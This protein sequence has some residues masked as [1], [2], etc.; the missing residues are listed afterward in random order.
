MDSDLPPLRDAPLQDMELAAGP[1]FTRGR[2]RAGTGRLSLQPRTGPRAWR[3][4]ISPTTHQTGTRPHSRGTEL[5]ID[6]CPSENDSPRELGRPV[7][8]CAGGGMPQ[9]PTPLKP[10]PTPPRRIGP[11]RRRMRPAREG[12]TSGNGP[13]TLRGA[14]NPFQGRRPTPTT[15]VRGCVR[16]PGSTRLFVLFFC[17]FLFGFRLMQR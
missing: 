3:G 13:D 15:L 4:G 11:S 5:G 17:L 8:S 10:R 7:E 1:Y 14:Y 12:P 6:G 16:I 9:P 2:S